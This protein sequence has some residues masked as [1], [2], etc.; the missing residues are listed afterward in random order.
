M[1]KIRPNGGEKKEMKV[2][3]YIA[4]TLN[5]L[6]DHLKN[7]VRGRKVLVFC[8][9][10]LTLEAE[11]AAASAQGAVFDVRVTTFARFLD[12]GTPRKVLTK[13]GSVLVVGGLPRTL[14]GS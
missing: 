4:P 1:K 8:E 5:A 7:L 12:D 10:R 13:Q 14:R 9:D 6:T 11:R 2:R 3:I